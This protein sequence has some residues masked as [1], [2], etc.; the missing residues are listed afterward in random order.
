MHMDE[1]DVIYCRKGI[2]IRALVD[3]KTV[4]KAY[5]ISNHFRVIV[6]RK[7]STKNAPGLKKNKIC[8]VSQKPLD[9]NKCL[10]K[11]R[12]KEYMVRSFLC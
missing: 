6:D 8:Y 11:K 3:H 10:K 7:I 9:N 1:Y 2:D 12:K 4:K 5:S